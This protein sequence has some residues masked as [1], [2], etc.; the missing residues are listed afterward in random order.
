MTDPTT[1]TATIGGLGSTAT[2]GVGH[3]LTADILVVGGGLGGVAAALSAL[4]HGRRVVLTEEY[5][6]LGGQLTSQAVPLDEHSWIE[7]FGATARYRRL[8]DGI[9]DHYR[10]FYPLTESARAERHAGG[11]DWEVEGTGFW[12]VHPAAADALVA[13]VAGFAEVRAGETVLDLYAGAGLFGGVLAPAAGA[14]GRVVCVES[15]EAACAAA[16]RASSI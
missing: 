2:A 4:E 13:A 9:R 16:A 3:E 11:R 5:A 7:Q 14:H 15:E 1:D 10:R 8:R 12:Q 6:W